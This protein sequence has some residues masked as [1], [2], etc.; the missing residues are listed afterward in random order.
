MTVD[1]VII[2]ER[3][4]AARKNAQLT[5]QQLAEKL[6]VSIAYISRVEVGSTHLNL[7]RLAQF[8]SVLNV[9]EGQIL[10]GV[11]SGQNYLSTEFVSILDKCSQKK[12][13]LIYSIAKIISEYYE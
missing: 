7:K 6:N 5:Q 4:K 11:T 12:Q 1:Y 13:K 9:S 2:G 3:L 8:C 10:N